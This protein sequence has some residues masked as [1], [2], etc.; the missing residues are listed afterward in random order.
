MATNSRVVQ[1]SQ[2]TS[3]SKKIFFCKFK[4][5]FSAFHTL[6]DTVANDARDISGRLY[7]ISARGSSNRGLFHDLYQ[8]RDVA[9][10]RIGLA[11]RKNEYNDFFI[12]YFRMYFI[13][14][15]CFQLMHPISLRVCKKIR[16]NYHM[17]SRILARTIL[18][19]VSIV[20]LILE[21]LEAR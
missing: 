15:F 6:S 7:F 11:R 14:L 5:G 10:L 20:I 1:I 3:N 12:G 4:R 2:Q 9:L 13:A 21:H 16:E 8:S 18:A 19:D 17:F